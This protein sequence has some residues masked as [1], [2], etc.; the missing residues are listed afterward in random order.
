MLLAWK[1]EQETIGMVNRQCLETI[2]ARKQCLLSTL[3]KK[4]ECGIDFGP[5]QST[6]N[7]WSSE[8]CN[9]D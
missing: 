6:L 3:Q 2:K 9:Y 1:V 4:N 7:L 8:L 5:I